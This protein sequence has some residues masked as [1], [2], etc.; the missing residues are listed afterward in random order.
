MSTFLN[1][2]LDSKT[3]IKFIQKHILFS[4]LWIIIFAIFL[5]RVDIVIFSKIKGLEWISGI[6]PILYTIFL[7]I[8]SLSQRWYS[9]VFIFYPIL[10]IFWFIPKTILTKGKIYLFGHYVNGVFKKLQNPRKTLIHLGIFIIPFIL[11]LST[12]NIYVR[13]ATIVIFGYFYLRY[14]F[15]YI[16]RSFKPAQ[17]FG[18]DIESALETLITQGTSNK[19]ALIDSY[20][21][22]KE[23]D[24]LPTQERSK[25]QISRLVLANYVLTFVSNNLN[26]YKGKRAYL[27]AWI[28]ELFIFLLVS[29]IFFWFVNYQ[30]Y[31]IDPS[32]FKLVGEATKFEFFY[33]T[34]KTITFGDIPSIL[35]DSIFSKTLEIFSFFVLGIFILIIVASI[36]FSFR[37]DKM[38][39][40]IELTTKICDEQNRMITEYMKTEFSTDV[41]SA[42]TEFSTIRDSI[43]KLQRLLR[44]LF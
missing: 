24:K 14:I 18:A 7:F 21:K 33:Y 28:Y 16:A 35:P 1:L 42:V 12:N 39:E 30:I 40:N 27:I 6:L 23:D 26:S 15:Q 19:S 36:I 34:L 4:I 10:A 41:Q 20:I 31:M 5:F 38:K 3:P 44:N 13:W 11:I 25:K 17:L 32:N 22:Q 8:F 9:L 43:D 2:E 37:Q 29:I